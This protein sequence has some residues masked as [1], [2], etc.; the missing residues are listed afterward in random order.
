MQV[1]IHS[2]VP[3]L[4]VPSA[5]LLFPF[6]YS[7]DRDAELFQHIRMFVSPKITKLHLATYNFGPSEYS[8][9]SCI[10]MCPF[11]SHFHD[12]SLINT[13]DLS[14]V[15]QS[16]SHLTSVLVSAVFEASILHL[17]KLPL[18]RFLRLSLPPIPMSMD[19][20]K[21]EHPAFCALQEL[22]M[23]CASSMLFSR[24]SSL[25]QNPYPLSMTAY[26]PLAISRL[27]NR[28]AHS[29]LER[30]KLVITDPPEDRIT[31]V[32]TAAL[33]PLFASCNL[34]KLNLRVY[35]RYV[36]QRDDAVLL[37]MAKAWPLLEVLHLINDRPRGWSHSECL[38][39]A[40]AALPVFSF[41]CRYRGLVYY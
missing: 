19:M 27:S 8:I 14:T 2:F 21:L 34:R 24:G 13:E 1:L 22:D 7:P 30:L 33:R 23:K 9:L 11:V 38:H 15:L 41:G 29:S 32:R 20:Q 26:M 17:S 36:S 16:W 28:C 39:L 3:K 40:G 4:G 25:L 5:V 18:L 35:H 6:P 12:R 37:Q 31:S 10:S